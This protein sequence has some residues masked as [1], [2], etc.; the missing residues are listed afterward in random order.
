MWRNPSN[1]LRSV[2]GCL[3]MIASVPVFVY[4]QVPARISLPA[5]SDVLAARSIN[6]D[7]AVYSEAG[8][9]LGIDTLQFESADPTIATV[10]SDAKLTGLLPGTT[11]VVVRSLDG[12]VEARTAVRV[13]PGRIEI[14]PAILEVRVGDTL[15]PSAR[16]L[17]A[18][19]Q[20]IPG[21]A[22]RW[23]V[24]NAAV[25]RATDG[26]V[27]PVAPGVTSVTVSLASLP[28]QPSFSAEAT[29]RVLP[30]RDYRIQRINTAATVGSGTIDSLGA[31]SASGEV[32]G[33][34]A[35]L[36]NGGQA[37]VVRENGAWRPIL[38]AGQYV[39]SL[40]LTANKISRISVN[41]RG[42]AVVMADGPFNW[43][44]TWLIF[45]PKRG[46]PELL[47]NACT[48]EITPGSMADDGSIQW[49]VWDSGVARLMKRD[50]KG[51]VT[52]TF[53]TAES[54]R[55]AASI[56]WAVFAR[57]GTALF[58]GTPSG[59]AATIYLA[60]GGKITPVYRAGDLLDRQAV[61]GID[62]PVAGQDGSY[63]AR[64][65]GNSITG[66]VRLAPGAIRNLALS[67]NAE[68]NPRVTWI[69]FAVD[70]LAGRV[71][72]VCDL[73]I[74]NEWR[75][76]LAAVTDTGIQQVSRLP[77]WYSYFEGQMMSQGALLSVMVA[78]DTK[79]TLRLYG[80]SGTPEVIDVRAPLSAPSAADWRFLGR[81]S[82]PNR[83]LSLGAGESLMEF[84][85]SGGRAVVPIG[86]ALPGGRGLGKI[87]NAATRAGQAV[88]SGRS[89]WTGIYRYRAGR[90]ETVFEADDKPAVEGSKLSWVW[91]HRGRYL[92]I[93]T[94]GD[95][96]GVAALDAN[97]SIFY[98][99]VSGA[100]RRLAARNQPAPGGGFYGNFDRVE[101][102]DLG[103]VYFTAAINGRQSLFGGTAGNVARL[104]TV[105]DSLS[106]R[107]LDSLLSL[108]AAGSKLYAV[109]STSSGRVLASYE[110][111][112]WTEVAAEGRTSVAGS[113]LSEFYRIEMAASTGGDVVLLARTSE[114]GLGLFA[115]TPSGNRIVTTVS[116]RL[117]GNEWLIEPQGV[118]MSDKGD[119]YFSAWVWLEGK[120]TLALYQAS[121]L[122]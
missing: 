75:T 8:A 78:G 19:G 62:T 5:W 46:T 63:V 50:A 96:A 106:G 56:D 10:T 21:V 95:V 9:R 87:Y 39:E 122:N 111:G 15:R 117:P 100:A 102:D 14:T 6:L 121:P 52:E 25:A 13:L 33:G 49:R 69:H 11:E 83:L 32:M 90:L 79:P 3:A 66:L 86:S 47:S 105:G 59:G 27:I 82:E 58:R 103:R 61:N 118:S 71:L 37:A 55:V 108:L 76:A 17:N 73:I 43:C 4:G 44:Q 2:L 89:N 60:E 20:V 74:D 29:L 12:T 97:D 92:A 18:D 35:T 28:A 38:A 31:L 115:F 68:A 113:V 24:E 91:G 51:T 98:A 30:K 94:I 116:D 54:P 107:T 114:L 84:S 48:G 80:A 101:L 65:S 77:G 42:D 40:G 93:N 120:E 1:S 64:W 99:P 67:T 81:A 119:I 34:I 53:S 112:A 72:M 110:R 45:F 85:P 57:T 88:L 104:W 23:L 26:V 36:S 70:S 109:F 16:V 41:A 7:V 22:V